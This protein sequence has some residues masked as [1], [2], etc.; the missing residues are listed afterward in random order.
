MFFKNSLE[1]GTLCV[2]VNVNFSIFPDRFLLYGPAELLVD[3]VH[4]VTNTKDWNPDLEN[5]IVILMSI[6]SINR[7]RSSRNN[8]SEV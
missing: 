6:F 4:S 5:L 1:Q 3:H 2:N 7:L 8:N